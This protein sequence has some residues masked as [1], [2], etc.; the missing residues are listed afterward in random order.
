MLN[1]SIM[2]TGDFFEQYIF[3]QKFH[4]DWFICFE[5]CCFF[6]S[7]VSH[8]VNIRRLS[9][10]FVQQS[11]VPFLQ[12][13]EGRLLHRSINIF[14]FVLSK[15]FTFVSHSL[16]FLISFLYYYGFSYLLSYLEFFVSF[17]SSNKF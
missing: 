4:F 5:R 10:E 14:L 16:Y 2:A 3:H 12:D 6:L 17:I 1:E 9:C 8:V 11:I 13:K 7:S 15:K